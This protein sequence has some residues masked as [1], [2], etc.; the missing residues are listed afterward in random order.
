MVVFVD[1]QRLTADDWPNYVPTNNQDYD[2]FGGKV[3]LDGDRAAVSLIRGVD[4]YS[5]SV[6][7]LQKKQTTKHGHSRWTSQGIINA[8]DGDQFD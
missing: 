6:F 4:Y 1:T 8:W 5:G 7:L 3:A 2:E